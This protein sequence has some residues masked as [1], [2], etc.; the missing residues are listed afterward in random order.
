MPRAR[1][2]SGCPKLVF[3]GTRP[4][5]GNKG[6]QRP[7]SQFAEPQRVCFPRRRSPSILHES[8]DSARE[9]LSMVKPSPLDLALGIGALV[10]FLALAIWLANFDPL[11]SKQRLR[12]TATSATRQ[13]QTDQ[14][15]TQ[16]LDHF[17]EHTTIIRERANRAVDQIQSAPTSGQVLDPA[18]RGVLCDSGLCDDPAVADDHSSKHVP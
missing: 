14:A 8:I 2:Y 9:I 18:F 5:L 16:A 12:D 10:L 3:S 15:T 11:G 7:P 13:A 17:I 6:N 4:R 1:R